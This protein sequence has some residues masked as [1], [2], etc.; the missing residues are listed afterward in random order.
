MVCT[1]NQF[2]R[3]MESIEKILGQAGL[4]VSLYTNPSQQSAIAEKELSRLGK[5]FWKVGVW[6]PGISLL[7]SFVIPLEGGTDAEE[8]RFRFQ[9]LGSVAW[10]ALPPALQLMCNSA[11]INPCFPAVPG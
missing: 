1:L 3:R 7:Q 2:P 8:R 4:N 6:K 9:Q 11:E 10:D 5:A